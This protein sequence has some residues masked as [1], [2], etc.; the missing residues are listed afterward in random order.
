MLAY[1]LA[2]FLVAAPIPDKVETAV[3]TYVETNFAQPSVEYQFD[4]KRVNYAVLPT[5]CD[6]VRVL[7]LGKNSPLGCTVFS[8]GIYKDNKLTRATPI[9]VEVSAL[10]NAIV[11]TVPI[12]TGEQLHGLTIAKRAIN[13]EAE[14]PVLDT[15]LLINKQ[16]T[17]Y[18]PA[19]TMILPTMVENVPVIHSGDKVNIVV[20]RGLIRI[21]APGIARQKGGRGDLI[22]VANLDSKKVIQAAVVDSL[23]VA[24]K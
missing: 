15:C 13:N 4:F 2:L 3:K 16:T 8:L 17:T 14:F 5:D 24:C 20:E 7:R 1:L 19:G 11:A 6:S 21:V 18:I 9:T 22:R 23:T 12:G 10:I